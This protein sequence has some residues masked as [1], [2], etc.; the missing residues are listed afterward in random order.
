MALIREKRNNRFSDTDLFDITLS[1]CNTLAKYLP[2]FLDFGITQEKIDNLIAFS[3]EFLNNLKH[4]IN[5]KDIVIATNNRNKLRESVKEEIRR[6]ALRCKLKW[7]NVS[8]QEKSLGIKRMTNFTDENLLFTANRVLTA[9]N[10]YLPELSEFGLTEAHLVQFADLNKSFEDAM[11][12]QKNL[13]NLRE[14]NTNERIKMGNELYKKIQQY[15]KMGKTVYFMTNEARYND[16]IIH[17]K[18]KSKKS[19]KKIEEV[20]GAETAADSIIPENIK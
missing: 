5:R 7:G 10:E 12:L 3:N 1:L 8:M 19:V 6:M 2:D 4:D 20:N 11:N 18:R 15:A 9:M 16:F 17:P 14:S 13:V